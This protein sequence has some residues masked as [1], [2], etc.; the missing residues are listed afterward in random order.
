MKVNRTNDCVLCHFGDI[1]VG[2]VAS[3]VIK[4][5]CSKLPRPQSLNKN[6]YVLKVCGRD[7]FFDRFV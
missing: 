1:P 7:E 3:H 5:T 6:E 4:V 2:T